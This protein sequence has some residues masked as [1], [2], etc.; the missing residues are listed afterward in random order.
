MVEVVR[1]KGIVTKRKQK[2]Y[3]DRKAR[4]RKLKVGQPDAVPFVIVRK[5]T[6]SNNHGII[7]S[8]VSGVSLEL[9]SRQTSGTE[10]CG[11]I[12]THMF[13]LTVSYALHNT[14]NGERIRMWRISLLA[15]FISATLAKNTYVVLIPRT[16]RPGLTLSV[17]VNILQA[18][19]RVKVEASLKKG[20]DVVA[21]SSKHFRSGKPGT[22]ELQVPADLTSGDYT[23][24]VV[25]SRGLTFSNSTSITYESKSMSVF[26]QTDKAIY[27][28]GQ[29]V[30]FRAFA[31]Y[32]NV[33]VHT[34]PM[35]VDIKDPKN[36][37]IKRMIGLQGPSGVIENQL[38]LDTHPILGVWKIEV[39]SEDHT[40]IKEFTVD[41]YVLPKFEVTVDLPSFALT[42][43][44]HVSGTITAKY[45]Y[46]KPIRGNALITS[47][48]ESSK[49]AEQTLPIDGT[50]T[51]HIDLAD[52]KRSQPN[53]N[54]R[55]LIVSANVT[56]TLTGISLGGSSSVQFF[57]DPA[58]IEFLD[59]N[60][61]S[62]KPGLEYAAYLRISQP[63][64][65]PVT[66]TQR[67]V[68]VKTTVTT[69]NNT[70]TLPVESFDVPADGVVDIRINVPN[71]ALEMNL[72]ISY[73]KQHIY[74]HLSKSYSP[75][76]NYIQLVLLSSKVTAGEKAK[77][78]MKSTELVCNAVYQIMSRGSIIAAKQIRLKKSGKFSI[79]IT[80]LMAPTAE[81]I[82]YYVRPDGEVVADTITFDVDGAFQNQVSLDFDQNQVLPG[83]NV[84]LIARADPNSF[85]AILAVDQSVLL[86]KGGN[87]IT[88]SQVLEDLQSYESNGKEPDIPYPPFIP[89]P[90][91]VGPP[92]VE[93]EPRIARM[94]RSIMFPYPLPPGGS[95]AWMLFNE[96]G[97]KVLTDA[98][99]YKRFMEYPH[100]RKDEM[101]IT[102]GPDE[103]LGGAKGLEEVTRIRFFFPET[104]L[105]SS[106]TTSADGTAIIQETVPDTIT[107][108]VASA[109]AVNNQT[110]LGITQD[111]TKVKAF[112]SFFVSLTLPYSLIRGEQVVIQAN[113]F[114]YL[115]EAMTVVVTLDSNDDFRSIRVD[116]NGIEE[117]VS[118]PQ[119]S[120]LLI[121]AGDAKTVKFPIVP[122]SLG[123]IPIQVRA[124]ST[125]AADAVRRIIVV[126]PEGVPMEYNIPVMVDLKESNTF[127]Q[128]IPLTL[129]ANTVPG[130][131]RSKVS[132][133]GDV[134][135][136]TIQ[137]LENLLRMPTGCGEQTLVSFAPDVFISSYLEA[138]GQFTGDI[139]DKALH[140]METGYQR[141]L[142]FQHDD[143]SFSAFGD[144]DDSG[145]TWLSAFVVK[146]F[147]GAKNFIYVDES[148]VEKAI[149]WMIS[150]QNADGSFPE[151]GRVIHKNMQGASA[152]GSSLTAYVLAALVEQGP[153]DSRTTVAVQK[154]ITYLTTIN[155]TD[156]YELAI[157]SYALTVAGDPSASVMFAKLDALATIKDGMKYWHKPEAS[158]TSP[159]RW[160][161]P[162]Q[163]AKSVDIEMTSYALLTYIRKN[164][165]TGGIPVMKWITSQRNSLG[166]YHSTQDT[167]LAL[168][169]LS[170]FATSMFSE[171][172]N[173]HI[174]VTV[175]GAIY[176]FDVSSENALVL[177]SV[178]LPSVPE[179]VDVS[180]T[181]SGFAL[182]EVAV[183]F[184]VEEDI[185][186]P[187]F[188]LSVELSDETLDSMKVQ[189]CFRW[190]TAGTSGMA[191][192]EFGVLS[193]FAVNP[194]SI[195][196]LPILKKIEVA[197]RKV[198]LYF[199][200]IGSDKI[201]TTFELE[202]VAMVAQSQPAAVRIYDYYEPTNKS[203]IV[204][205]SS[206]SPWEKTANSE[207]RSKARHFLILQMSLNS[208]ENKQYP[209]YCVC[210]IL[211]VFCSGSIHEDQSRF[212]AP[213]K[214]GV[215]T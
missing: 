72:D 36:N 174:T 64:G 142:T 190:L 40:E 87:D 191:I 147:R 25:G 178:A 123:D 82:A 1:D 187:S 31:M 20:K 211:L 205:R 130:S 47:G 144:R 108:W 210:Y 197:D 209:T 214:L 195:E 91:P 183:Y 131:E 194:D 122:V 198:V 10:M 76:D 166:G 188:S 112:Q 106:I 38:V 102:A 73:G 201:C 126:E 30:H 18:S 176:E 84:G 170:E 93:E 125:S 92:M 169:A 41:E 63:D 200:E 51:F 165:I 98:T 110:G 149:D 202:R 109:F 127:T 141:E 172:G 78:E 15:I 44:D 9:V 57:A 86:L 189:T 185:E 75:S 193:G 105:W 143:G 32:P 71:D 117:H 161:S 17:S 81:L 145:S 60:S 66:T 6:V 115:T 68:L 100:Y 168:Q 69:D 104:W 192:Q 150:M 101:K 167:V 48:L 90:M 213:A 103:A 146:S 203:A 175:E 138:T 107:S 59:T 179:T 53:L 13:D 83:E 215:W 29:T 171:D 14:S 158:S 11:A 212:S 7:D 52:I 33:T 50:V 154:A 55:K 99:V 196:R 135:G 129:P 139:R 21:T 46:G 8:D 56:E 148:V 3:Y 24:S 45:T 119:V 37:K 128:V 61:K 186:E 151:P 160:R 173:I 89:G 12:G 155:I 206:V 65:R 164:D 153:I 88:E 97:V 96:A 42:C 199:D 157:S 80:H 140:F 136:P 27:K 5:R 134:M 133:I 182:L 58:K 132:V 49:L 28:P 54:N 23:L 74:E 95:D 16:F 111:S 116:E 124:Q 26:I 85:V 121:P 2:V 177:Q 22:M 94:K 207:M 162:N 43:D 137:G 120:T 152:T 34:G 114:N 163:Q 67:D 181:G 77:F 118:A 79:P 180:A 159:P 70:Y 4:S 39:T 35:D 19:R 113:V 208:N 62:F 156:M 204:L 184:Y